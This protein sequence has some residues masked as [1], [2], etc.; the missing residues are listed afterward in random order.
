MKSIPRSCSVTLNDIPINKEIHVS[1]RSG[2]SPCS[3]N[4][5]CTSSMP[6]MIEM[7]SRSSS[8][9]LMILSKSRSIIVLGGGRNGPRPAGPGAT[10]STQV[11]LAAELLRLRPLCHRSHKAASKGGQYGD[12]HGLPAGA[13]VKPRRGLNPH[14]VT[15]R[16]EG[17]DHDDRLPP[18]EVL[19][20]VQHL[21]LL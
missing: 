13:S 8:T 4:R 11:G 21:Q 10:A 18:E 3:R 5:P 15:Q 1:S 19:D 17:V 16:A 9:S 6:S 14:A 2:S 7:S 20:L 12:T